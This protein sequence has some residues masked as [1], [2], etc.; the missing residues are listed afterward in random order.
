MHLFDWLFR[1]DARKRGWHVARHGRDQM[2]Y[3]EFGT[4][5]TRQIMIDG[6]MLYGRPRHVIYFASPEQWRQKYP[7]WA[8][9]RRDE[10]IARIKSELKE[11][12]YEYTGV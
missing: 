1:P 7:D 9:D 5:E 8:R 12:D 4:G 10:I 11:P 6:E 2:R 3:E